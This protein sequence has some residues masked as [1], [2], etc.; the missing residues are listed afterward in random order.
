M[1]T[2]LPSKISVSGSKKQTRN[3]WANVTPDLSAGCWSSDAKRLL[4]HC[5][6][7]KRQFRIYD[8]I[9][10]THV[11]ES[12]GW[13]W[14]ITLLTC[15]TYNLN[16][17]CA[18]CDKLLSD[19]FEGRKFSLFLCLPKLSSQRSGLSESWCHHHGCSHGH[20]HG[21][22]WTRYRN[23]LDWPPPAPCQLSTAE[24]TSYVMRAWI[25]TSEDNPNWTSIYDGGRDGLKVKMNSK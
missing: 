17:C 4:I 13:S 8:I 24:L 18:S 22:A 23:C 5:L 10:A 20:G 9:C 11:C 12:C 16:Q 3:T 1:Q 6:C 15:F 2:K 7:A 19:R 21:P 25:D 14:M